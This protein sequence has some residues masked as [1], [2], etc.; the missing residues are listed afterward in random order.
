MRLDDIGRQGLAGDRRI[1][2]HRDHRNPPGGQTP[3]GMVGTVMAVVHLYGVRA[4][5]TGQELM[6]EA[7]AKNWSARFQDFLH[8]KC[9]INDGTAAAANSP[10]CRSPESAFCFLG[11]G[12]CDPRDSGVRLF[13]SHPFTI[14]PVGPNGH[15]AVLELTSHDRE[16]KLFKMLSRLPGF[17]HQ[18]RCAPRIGMR[19][20]EDQ[21]LVVKSTIER[22]IPF[23][24]PSTSILFDHGLQ[25]FAIKFLHG[26]KHM[27]PA[28]MLKC[29]LSSP[30]LLVPGF[31]RTEPP[32]KPRS[33]VP[34]W[35][36]TG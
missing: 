36:K 23:N 11:A 17:E 33:G 4:E 32:A 27:L 30:K 8:R 28:N 2:I 3:H 35:Q 12:H 31:K 21:F 18:G 13:D 14:I 15:R 7:D 6:A 9:H 24:R 20:P 26:S 5:S 25:S 10:C 22:D 16:P 29:H 34:S 1:V 19:R